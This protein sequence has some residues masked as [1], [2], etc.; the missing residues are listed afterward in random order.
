[1]A[2]T[3]LSY[4]ED[5]GGGGSNLP[6]A[7]IDKHRDLRNWIAMSQSLTLK[8]NT[9]RREKDLCLKVLLRHC[10]SFTYLNYYTGSVLIVFENYR[11]LQKRDQKWLSGIREWTL[12]IAILHGNWQA[13]CDGFRSR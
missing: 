12:H 13:T 3:V 4:E 2:M 9:L 11:S 5:H 10:G 7:I 8:M 1:M 6:L